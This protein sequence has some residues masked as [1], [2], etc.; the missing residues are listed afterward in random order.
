MTSTNFRSVTGWTNSGD[1]NYDYGAIILPTEPRQHRRLVRLRRLL[2]CRPHGG[3]GNISGYPG[4]KPRGTQWYDSHKIAS[5]NSRKVYYDID[6]AG[7]QSGSA[8]YR[9]IN[10]DRYGIADPRLRRRHDQLRHAH[11]HAGVQQHGGLEGMKRG[12]APWQARS[13]GVVLDAAG[14]PVAQARVYFT[15]SPGPTPDIAALTGSDGTFR[16]NAPRAGRYRI[17]AIQ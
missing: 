12:P 3:T 6:T 9:I 5:V 11:R 10:G 1:E 4:D 7:G 15:A 13:A 14:R 17:G 16:M 2:G 8:V